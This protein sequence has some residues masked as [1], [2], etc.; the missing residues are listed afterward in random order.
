M[1]L[2]CH[3]GQFSPTQDARAPEEIILGEIQVGNQIRPSKL[4]FCV[5][6]WCFWRL[7]EC[8]LYV[9]CAFWMPWGIDMALG[10]RKKA[11]ICGQIIFWHLMERCAACQTMFVTHW[12]S[13]Q[14]DCHRSFFV[15]TFLGTSV[16]VKLW[17]TAQLLFRRPHTWPYCVWISCWILV[18]P[19]LRHCIVIL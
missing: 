18:E 12:S 1:R 14:A 7:F 19:Q 6:Q 3:G 13:L 15:V 5:G 2:W 4:L 16:S 9:Q 11:R 17:S 8:L 10:L